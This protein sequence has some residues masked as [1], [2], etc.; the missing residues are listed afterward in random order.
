MKTNY[1]KCQV[2]ER[3]K[4]RKYYE[5]GVSFCEQLIWEFIIKM[6]GWS[7]ASYMEFGINMKTNYKSIKWQAT[8]KW[9]NWTY[10]S[11][12][13]LEEKYEFW[14]IKFTEEFSNKMAKQY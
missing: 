7:A 9:R 6:R 12:D 2:I 11:T 14:K 5:L 4:R 13:T 8:T 10:N 1:M 3:Q